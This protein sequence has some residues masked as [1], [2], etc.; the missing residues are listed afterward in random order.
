MLLLLIRMSG[1]LV[2]KLALLEVADVLHSSEAL[3][4]SYVCAQSHHGLSA[5][6]LIC[7]AL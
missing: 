5:M 2:T 4:P 1:I 7:L 3:C 6:K